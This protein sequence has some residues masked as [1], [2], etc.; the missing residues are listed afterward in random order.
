MSLGIYAEK[1]GMSQIFSENGIRTPVTLLKWNKCVVL[2]HKTIESCGYDAVV[3]GFEEVSEKKLNKP[4]VVALQKLNSALFKNIREF[5]G[6]FQ[7][8]EVGSEISVEDVFSSVTYVDVASTSKGKGF[9]G[10]MKRH[11]FGGL[12]ASHGVSI[13]HRSHGSTGNLRKQGKVFKGKKMAGH[14]GNTSVT[15][16]NLKLVKID[17]ENNLII[18]KGCV[19]GHTGTLL[20]VIP[21][22]KK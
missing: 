19:P 21:A 10:V 8:L 2:A 6:N 16:Q 7:H 9:A 12:R 5:R 13:S 18:V 3:V 1:V 4:Q 17:K 11:S 15:V 14:M 20:R 22:I